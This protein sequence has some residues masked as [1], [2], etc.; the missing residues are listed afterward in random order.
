MHDVCR[1]PAGMQLLRHEFHRAVD[2]RKEHPVSLAQIIQTRL[3]LRSYSKPVFRTFT[4][5]R[6]KDRAFTAVFRKFFLFITSKLSLSFTINQ[7]SE[8]NCQDIAQQV[9][10]VDKMIA[11]VNIA[12]MFDHH[13]RSAYRRKDTYP[14]RFPVPVCKGGIEMLDVDR[15]HVTLNPF[16]KDPGQELPDTVP[17]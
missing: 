16:I 15:S 17:D 7:L 9:V 10:P 5:A 11:R 12:V 8:R 4:P 6:E 1:C 14:M 3:T 2:M 13:C